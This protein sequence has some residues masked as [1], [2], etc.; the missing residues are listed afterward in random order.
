[1]EVLLCG[2]DAGVY[3]V[4]VQSGA[5]VQH[6]K[7]SCTCSRAFGPVGN[8][9]VYISAAQTHKPLLMVWHWGKEQPCYRAALPERITASSWSSDGS[10]LFAGGGSGQVFVWHVCTGHLVRCW[11]CHFKAVTAVVVSDNDSLLFTAS[12][13]TMVQVF[14]M[15]TV[16]EEQSPQA[17]RSWSGHSLPVTS[18]A[19]LGSL[20]GRVASSGMDRCLKVWEVN[21]GACKS[22]VLPAYANQVVFSSDGKCVF[23][24]CNDATIRKVE[25]NSDEAAAV[26]IGHVGAVRALSLTM[27]GQTLASCAND[28]VRLWDV[29]TRQTIRHLEGQFRGAQVR[30]V[31]VV[32]RLAQQRGGKLHPVHSM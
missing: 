6:F 30:S 19:V 12:E 5:V 7:D 11:P 1:M 24:G 2:T 28:G 17:L 9:T 8:D 18:L 15:A 3:A 21:S 29:R 32:Q 31:R 10:F 14:S 23:A 26:Y 13:D 25:I 22:V 16:L 4:D 27:D 20:D